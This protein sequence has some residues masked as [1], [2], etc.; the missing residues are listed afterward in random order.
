MISAPWLIWL[1]HSLALLKPYLNSF[2]W[3]IRCPELPW[4]NKNW[5]I[6]SNDIKW[7]SKAQ[8]E[9]V[10]MIIFLHEVQ[11]VGHEPSRTRTISW[12]RGLNLW[13][14]L[15]EICNLP[16]TVIS[17]FPIGTYSYCREFSGVQKPP[18]G[19]DQILD[20]GSIVPRN[21]QKYRR[22][23]ESKAFS[24]R[25]FI[26]WQ[27]TLL[28]WAVICKACHKSGAPQFLASSIIPKQQSDSMLFHAS[29]WTMLDQ[30]GLSWTYLTLRKKV[31]HICMCPIL[32]QNEL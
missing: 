3:L 2:C 14:L 29:Y 19:P 21:R 30:V 13:L 20:Q 16:S 32:R 23:T 7:I 31:L 17:S 22:K 24:V 15:I 12:P 8:S 26:E 9:C 1:A 4:D 18:E 27:V 11:S 25:I 10:L 6:W 5:G 28:L